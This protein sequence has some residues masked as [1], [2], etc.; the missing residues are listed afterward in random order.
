MGAA[1]ETVTVTRKQLR[2]AVRHWDVK[3]TVNDW[4]KV[5]GE[6]VDALSKRN[7]DY[8]FDLLKNGA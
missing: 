1:K 8:L 7:G 3:S 4:Q 5:E 6:D 2:R